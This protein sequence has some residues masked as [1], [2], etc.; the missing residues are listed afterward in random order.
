MRRSPCSLLLDVV[1]FVGLALADNAYGWSIIDAPWWTWLL[2]ASP[3]LILMILLL[4][5]PLA[6]LSPGRL[7]NVEH[8][9]AGAPRR[10]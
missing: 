10:R 3:A 2:L 4:A 1:L 8:R 9:A 6:E 7:R 5:V